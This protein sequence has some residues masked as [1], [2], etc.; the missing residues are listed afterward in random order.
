M[1]TLRYFE[2]KD[3]KQLMDWVETAEFMLQWAG[4]SFVYPL[5]E[6]QLMEYLKDANKK[7]S[8]SYIYSVIDEQT[9]KLVGHVSLSR[10]DRNNRSARIGRVILGDPNTKGKGFCCQM[11]QQVLKIAFDELNLH[12]VTLGVFDFNKAAIACYEK[13]GFQKE[14]LMRDHQKFG[15]DY[16]S[17]W[18]MGILEDEWRE[19]TE[20]A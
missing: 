19:I 14:G 2:Q 1:I 3:F 12:R 16:W 4:P 20:R 5:N 15:D 18:E 7:D 11:I 8:T 10:I 13:A 17:L 9:Q 6:F